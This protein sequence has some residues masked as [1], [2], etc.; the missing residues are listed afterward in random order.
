MTPREEADREHRAMLFGES[1]RTVVV[2]V[3]CA[4][5]VMG[6][7]A[8]GPIGFILGLVGASFICRNAFK[9]E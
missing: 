8:L 6:S 4:M 7:L 3:I 2:L 5:I 9:A 1:V